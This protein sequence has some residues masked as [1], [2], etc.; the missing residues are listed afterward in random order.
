M[1]L[2]VAGIKNEGRCISI[3]SAAGIIQKR[4][5]LFYRYDSW[6]VFIIFVA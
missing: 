3:L 4:L 1:A 5:R 6:P 2:R